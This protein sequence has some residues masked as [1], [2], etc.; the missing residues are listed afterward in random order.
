MLSKRSRFALGSWHGIMEC[1]PSML[2]FRDLIKKYQQTQAGT[3]LDHTLDSEC[4]DRMR[5]SGCFE[6]L[7]HVVYAWSI[8]RSKHKLCCWQCVT[9]EYVLFLSWLNVDHSACQIF[10]CTGRRI[11]IVIHLLTYV[12]LSSLK[13]IISLKKATPHLCCNE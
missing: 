10:W 6:V 2:P 8:K 3:H 11:I 4:Q 13:Y 1:H 12:V 9:T 5:T 7:H